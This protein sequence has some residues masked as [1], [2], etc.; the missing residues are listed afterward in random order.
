[1]PPATFFRTHVVS[2]YVPWLLS[3]GAY[4]WDR[5][6]SMDRV[7]AQRAIRGEDFELNRESEY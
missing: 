4:V 7:E 6:K 2:G 3:F 1:M 5:R